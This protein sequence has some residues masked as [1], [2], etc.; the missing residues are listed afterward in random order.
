[1]A[2]SLDDFHAAR[3]TVETVLNR[4]LEDHE[5]ARMTI[6]AQGGVG[7]LDWARERLHR[8]CR[9]LPALTLSALGIAAARLLA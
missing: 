4:N 7:A 6:L 3:R 1:M 9:E 8:C 5:L 2:R